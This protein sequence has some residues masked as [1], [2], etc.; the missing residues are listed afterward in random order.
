MN[1]KKLFIHIPK[2]AGLTV[3]RGLKDYIIVCNKNT[4]ISKYYEKNLTKTMRRAN[5][6]PGYEHARWRDIN[7]KLTDYYKAFAFVRNPWMKV[8]SRYMYGLRSIFKGRAPKGYVPSSF[9]EFLDE[10]FIY[11]NKEF[12]WH[13]PTRGWYQQFDY[14]TNIKEKLVCDILRFEHFEKDIRAYLNLPNNMKIRPSNNHHRRTHDLKWDINYKN[15]YTDKTIQIVADW[16]NK[17]IETFGFTFDSSATK[18]IWKT[19]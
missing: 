2:N 4:L 10:R 1:S 9:E 7:S 12:Y 5:E 15:L 19:S 11:G 16:Y 17:D 13:R 6:H 8:G 18:N 14:V 3:R